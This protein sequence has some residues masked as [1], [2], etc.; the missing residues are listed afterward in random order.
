MNMI[1]LITKKKEGDAL[2]GD[3]LK[4][5]VNGYTRGDIPDYQASAFLM[6]VYF[7][8]MDA[9]ETYLLTKA[10]IESGETL[11]LSG[12]NGVKLDKHS[13][14]GVGDK[15]SLIVAPIV[16]SCGGK[17]AKMS[18]RGLGHTG[19]T[20]DKLESIDGFK[21]SISI[22]EFINNVNDIGLSIIGQTCEL[23][24]ADKKLYRLRDVTATVDSLPLIASSIMSK[25]IAA[26]ADAVIL[27][28]KYGSGAFMKDIESARE[29]RQ[30]SRL[31]TFGYER[32]GGQGHRQFS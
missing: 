29:S 1:E 24:P 19:G 8:G 27:D 10:M 16:A 21:T 25:K 13:T 4:Y 22:Q 5:F 7:Q 20:I 15:T 30:K 28:I 6:A 14:G 31:Y 26:G 11:D 32:T 17:V 12:I 2:S 18:G 23:V 9:E 3:E